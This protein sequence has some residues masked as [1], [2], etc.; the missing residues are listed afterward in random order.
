MCMLS[1]I[2]AGVEIN[3]QDLLNG[4]IIN[5]DGSGW[6]IATPDVITMGKSMKVEEALDEFVTARD[7][8]PGCD[9]LF[10]SRWATHGTTG[11]ANVH[12]FLV[13]GSHKTVV[14]H[15]GILPCKPGKSDWRSDTR[16]LADEFLPTKYRR[17]DK[18]T[19][20]EQLAGYIGPNNKLCIL[21][22]DKRYRKNAYLINE[23]AGNWD[24]KTSV[25]HSNYDYL[26]RQYAAPKRATSYH[27]NS[28]GFWVSTSSCEFCEFCGYGLI[29]KAGYC[30]ECGTCNDCGEFRRECQCYSSYYRNFDWNQSTIGRSV[31]AIGQKA[32]DATK[33]TKELPLPEVT[34]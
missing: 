26:G 34:D 31:S 25:W 8:H 17:F 32:I 22:V 15:N 33:C 30:I 14:A 9:A 19:A 6:A 1:Y 5:G 18:E 12:P 13:G 2:P 28:A 16:I 29:G 7:K 4:G 10:H 21:T 24:K 3:T 11:I 23:K 27:K 20:M